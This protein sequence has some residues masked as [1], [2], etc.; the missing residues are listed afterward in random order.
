MVQPA[1][2][3]YYQ[4]L[5]QSIMAEPELSDSQRIESLYNELPSVDFS[6]RVLPAQTRR[7]SVLAMGDVGWTDLGDPDRVLA[8][9]SARK[10]AKPVA[11]EVSRSSQW[12]Y[13]RLRVAGGGL[14]G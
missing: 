8:L 7:L 13:A 6:S 10:R 9:L 11:Q 4:P 12:P 14:A 2:P 1:A 3:E 5:E